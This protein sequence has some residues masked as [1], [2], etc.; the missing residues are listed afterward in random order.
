[1]A[2]ADVVPREGAGVVDSPSWDHHVAIAALEG[3]DAGHPVLVG[4]RPDDPTLVIVRDATIAHQDA[5]G[6]VGDQ[7]IEGG[8]VVLVDCVQ[9]R[10]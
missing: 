1:M 2:E 3:Q 7:L 10:D 9:L 4:E 8:D 5:T 6:R